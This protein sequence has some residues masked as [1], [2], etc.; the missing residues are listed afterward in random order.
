MINTDKTIP[1]R[2]SPAELENLRILRKKIKFFGS[3]EDGEQEKMAREIKVKY[4]D[5]EPMNT[6]VGKD[7]P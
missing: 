4:S 5:P 7:T 1:Y 2:P 6:S 3:D